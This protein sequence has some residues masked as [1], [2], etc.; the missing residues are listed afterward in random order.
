MPR[1]AE[2][3]ALPPPPDIAGAA[4]HWVRE[5]LEGHNP[6]PFPAQ[7]AERK[8][9]NLITTLRGQGLW[10]SP[11]CIIRAMLQNS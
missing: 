3:P 4:I 9:W 8:D 1:A 6:A 2:R 7:K 5:A 11:T 10:L